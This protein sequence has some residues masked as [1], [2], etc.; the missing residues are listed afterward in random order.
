[1]VADVEVEVKAVNGNGTDVPPQ[2]QHQQQQQSPESQQLQEEQKHLEQEKDISNISTLKNE[3]DEK[4]DMV[5]T[6]SDDD[7]D[8][9]KN[10]PDRENAEEH[11][12]NVRGILQQQESIRRAIIHRQKS[13]ASIKSQQRQPIVKKKKTPPKT[14]PKPKMNKKTSSTTSATESRFTLP[15]APIIIID[16]IDNLSYAELQNYYAD[17]ESEKELLQNLMRGRTK[18]AAACSTEKTCDT[19]NRTR[20]STFN[21]TY[22]TGEGKR[23]HTDA[24]ERLQLIT[25]EVQRAHTHMTRLVSKMV[26]DA[27]KGS[28]T[29]KTTFK[30]Y[31]SAESL[32]KFPHLLEKGYTSEPSVVVEDDNADGN[33][34]T[35]GVG[36]ESSIII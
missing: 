31:A 17:L 2:Q 13:N 11:F 33:E 28:S 12:K 1:M 27:G 21:V 8:M 19:D 34:N 14:K 3:N 10:I 18:S 30:R 24:H 26:G 6:T 22:D 23:T 20:S 5:F 7:E 32:R 15:R 4:N 36:E 29:T 16:T 35:I 9:L 25:A